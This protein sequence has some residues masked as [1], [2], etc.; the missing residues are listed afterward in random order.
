MKKLDKQ[1]FIKRT[2]QEFQQYS[3]N[4]ITD[5]QA[6][7]IQTNLFDFVNLLI[8]W[9]KNKQK[10]M[11][12]ETCSSQASKLLLHKQSCKISNTQKP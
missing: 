11:S 1:N 9:D 5:E 6:I 2:K 7:E 8:E 12:C 10:E 4:P 3:E